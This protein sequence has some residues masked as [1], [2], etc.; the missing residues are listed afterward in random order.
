MEHLNRKKKDR[1]PLYAM[2]PVILLISYHLGKLYGR[3]ITIDNL[4]AEVK[5]ALLTPLD[6]RFTPWTGR[7][8]L[9]GT[10]VWLFLFLRL[11]MEE[12]NL[13]PGLEYGSARLGD[14]RTISR[15]LTDPEN[16]EFYKIL[17]EHLTMSLNSFYTKLNNNVLTIGGSGS[18]KTFFYV[19][20]NALRGQTSMIFTDPKAELFKKLGNV[21]KTLG[22]RIVTI[23]LVDM[24]KSDHYN[25]FAYIRSDNDII[26]LV[27][28]I[29]TNTLPKGSNPSDPFWENA[30]ALYFQAIFSY[31]WYESPK[32]GR[33]ANMREV[34]RLLNMAKVAEKE[35]EKSPLDELMYVLP[36]DHPARVAYEKVRSGAKDTIRSI[37]ISAHARLAFLQ[38]PEILRILDDDDIDIR[39]IGE[40]VYHNPDRKTAVFC[41]IPD[42]DKSYNFLIGVFY[43][44]TFQELY[45]VADFEYDGSLPVPVV[46]WMDEFANVAL[47]DGFV[48]ILSTMRSRNISCNIILQNKAQL[49]ALFKDSY[50]TVIGNCDATVYLGGNES[51]THKFISE[52][53]GR[54]TVDKQSTGETRG[55]HGSSSRNF[56]VLGREL[57]MPDEVRKL[58]NSKCIVFIRG[59]EPVIDDKCHTWEREEY[60]A[61][62]AMGLYEGE[63]TTEKLYKE[64]QLNFHI[65]A[66]GENGLEKSYRY[67]IENYQAVFQEGKVLE[68]MKKLDGRYLAA[69]D[70]FGTYMYRHDGVQ[71]E[72]KPVID[73]GRMEVIESGGGRLHMYPVI[74]CYDVE[75]GEML[76]IS[77][78]V[79]SNPDL[80]KKI[81]EIF[82]TANYTTPKKKMLLNGMKP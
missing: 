73:P 42:N 69:P 74:G 50:Q 44:Q 33:K 72:T 21:L 49:Q 60:I 20:V 24:A 14:P 27:T 23:N 3:G 68:A 41:I 53:L 43:S 10:A 34:L 62:Q 52:M 81:N 57:L 7:F 54:Y 17:S 79:D 5:H 64:G 6:W 67:Q 22:Y 78:S 77:K 37:I 40:G 9:T 80:S 4:M 16:P 29:L 25:P 32:H 11:H 61:S 70:E 47:P 59:F 15:K 45:Y 19:L 1:R 82:R 13:I 71:N 30:L 38:N 12:R 31:V 56:D 75:H 39:S 18:G 46:L 8:L 48:E 58:D 28:N 35:G 51:E 63:E 76:F 36:E 26:K 66:E 65:Y 55:Q 2:L